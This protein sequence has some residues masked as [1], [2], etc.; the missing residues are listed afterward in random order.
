MGEGL[1]INDPRVE[2]A[3]RKWVIIYLS[4]FGFEVVIVDPKLELLIKNKEKM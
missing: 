1:D 2:L 4:I 3:L